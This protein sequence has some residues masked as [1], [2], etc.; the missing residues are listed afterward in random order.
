MLE[1]HQSSRDCT[2]PWRNCFRWTKEHPFEV[3]KLKE[4]DI[5]HKLPPATTQCLI[6]FCCNDGSYRNNVLLLVK[7]EGFL[8][9]TRATTPL[10]LWRIH[11]FLGALC[12]PHLLVTSFWAVGTGSPASGT[13]R[14][15]DESF[16]YCV[17]IGNQGKFKGLQPQHLTR[18]IIAVLAVDGARG[19]SG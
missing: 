12:L 10:F 14:E 5:K 19:R 4:N 16:W 7:S 17:L 8:A 3:W 18:R 15:K 11:G 9:A 1:S 13:R 6:I 2:L